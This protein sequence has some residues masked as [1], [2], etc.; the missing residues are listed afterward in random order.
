MSPQATGRHAN[1]THGCA[2]VL[3]GA[4]VALVE[5]AHVD[6]DRVLLRHHLVVLVRLDVDGV[7]VLRRGLCC[8]TLFKSCSGVRLKGVTDWMQ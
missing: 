2:C 7:V 6:D 5:V 1:R 4:D 8:D 3:L